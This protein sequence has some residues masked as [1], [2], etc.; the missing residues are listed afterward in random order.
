[1]NKQ[2]SIFK[3]LLYFAVCL[4]V[5]F[6]FVACE[7]TQDEPI[8]TV[9]EQQ[10]LTPVAYASDRYR[11]ESDYLSTPKEKKYAPVFHLFFYFLILQ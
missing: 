3:G 2:K 4:F 9:K 1:M 7:K 6:S 10:E 11:H 8:A 5:D